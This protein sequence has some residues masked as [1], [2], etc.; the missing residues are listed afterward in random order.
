[1]KR[2]SKYIKVGQSY[3]EQFKSLPEEQVV[4]KLQ[5]EWWSKTIFQQMFSPPLSTLRDTISFVLVQR[6]VGG[7]QWY[8]IKEG[9]IGSSKFSFYLSFPPDLTLNVQSHV[10]SATV[11]ILVPIY[12]HRG[13]RSTNN[14]FHT[15][16][17]FMSS[18]FFLE[19]YLMLLTA[20]FLCL[21][22]RLLDSTITW[23]SK[24][25]LVNIGSLR[26]RCCSCP[27]TSLF[28]SGIKSSSSIRS[29]NSD[30][31]HDQRLA[32]WTPTWVSPRRGSVGILRSWPALLRT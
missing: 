12:L 4:M 18:Q 2:W 20:L 22:F 21:F 23:N 15:F 25:R 26:K 29:P 11:I 27:Y 1:M 14:N 6:E 17:V 19:K 32:T 9:L 13:P 8:V 31:N 24:Q 3:S 10:F 28:F 7:D 16:S 30:L 5:I